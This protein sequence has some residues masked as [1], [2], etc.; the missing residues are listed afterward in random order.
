MFIIKNDFCLN[1]GASININY[2]VKKQ[3]N[4]TYTQNIKLGYTE[5]YPNGIIANTIKNQLTKNNINTELCQYNL[6]SECSCVIKI[7]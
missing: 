1:N 7:A 5:F 2:N 4:L 6:W 3:K